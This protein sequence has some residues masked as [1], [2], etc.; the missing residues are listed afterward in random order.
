MPLYESVC[1]SNE[2]PLA[3]WPVEHF[4]WTADEPMMNCTICGGTTEK[5]ASAF[6]VVFTGPMSARYNDRGKEGAHLD[7]H[8]AYE[9]GMDGKTK[10]TFLE[11][12][13]DQR[14]YVKRNNLANPT[15]MPRNFEVSEDGKT[16]AN[17]RGLPGTEL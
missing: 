3:D 11:T 12:W 16:A 1:R 5:I 4:Y 7:G 8:W 2:C 14:A 13:D 10:A 17:T 6:N 15:E 9:K